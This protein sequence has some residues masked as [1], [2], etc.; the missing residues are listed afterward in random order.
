M[1]PSHHPKWAFAPCGAK[2]KICCVVLPMGDL[3]EV[4]TS[5]L[6]VL[7]SLQIVEVTFNDP[8]IHLWQ[9]VNNSPPKGN[10]HPHIRTCRH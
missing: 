5:T 10:F 2:R 4:R 7:V 9:V 8:R 3:H 6:L 1:L